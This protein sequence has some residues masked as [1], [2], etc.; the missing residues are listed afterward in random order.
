M[1]MT[2]SVYLLVSGKLMI[3]SVHVH[4]HGHAMC[5]YLFTLAKELFYERNGD[6]DIMYDFIIIICLISK[7]NLF[8]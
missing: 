4:G 3:S 1:M 6:S 8:G 7:L 5:N 2:L